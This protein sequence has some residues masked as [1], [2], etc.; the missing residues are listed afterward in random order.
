[1]L[2]KII[3]TSI[4][5][6]L[7]CSAS[8]ASTADVSASAITGVSFEK[9]QEG[10][11]ASLDQVRVNLTSEIN[12]FSELKVSTKIS[13]AGT[14]SL[15]EA[16]VTFDDLIANTT[17]LPNLVPLKSKFG[18]QYLDF[19]SSNVYKTQAT[20]ASRSLA[21]TNF[22]GS[23][24]SPLKGDGLRA[25]VGHSALDGLGQVSFSVL[26]A[27]ANSSQVG[28]DGR[29]AAFAYDNSVAGI[30]FGV[31]YASDFDSDD[32]TTLMGL[33]AS[34]DY[35]TPMGNTVALSAEL[36]SADYSSNTQTGS[37]VSAVYGLNESVDLGVRYSMIDEHTTITEENALSLLVTRQLGDS[38]KSKFEYTKLNEADTDTFT[39]SIYVGIH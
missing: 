2:K 1:M 4:L 24:A 25:I 12:E 33:N 27:Q 8:F 17:P 35:E 28:Y 30:D 3:V 20:F 21:A 18:R 36:F 19:G 32:A 29:F 26:E 6:M 9:G 11:T 16:Y 37:S 39:A 22:L 23:S 10:G 14:L 7:M 13:S 38:A 34:M 5:S 31:D 15:S